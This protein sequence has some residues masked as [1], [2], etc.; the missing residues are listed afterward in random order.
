MLPSTQDLFNSKPIESPSLEQMKSRQ[1]EFDRRHNP[2]SEFVIHAIDKEYARKIK[3]EEQKVEITEELIRKEFVGYM[4]FYEEFQ[5]SLG[6][7]K[8]WRID[9][10][11]KPKYRSIVTLVFNQ[12][13]YLMDPERSQLTCPKSLML[14]GESNKGK[15]TIMSWFVRPIFTKYLHNLMIPFH[16]ARSLDEYGN[17]L[18]SDK[19]IFID[20][21]G[22]ELNTNKDSKGFLISKSDIAMNTFEILDNR[23]IHKKITN[24]TTNLTVEAI[25]QLYSARSEWRFEEQ[26]EIIEFI[27]NN[28]DGSSNDSAR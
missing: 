23:R 18:Y 12:L 10:E 14:I 28:Q 26:F 19:L 21:L 20:D 15:T 1:A 25:S 11:D 6:A 2:R 3:S 9:E 4:R 24:I 22:M 7:R 5:S 17:S 8:V 16:K 27:N 13:V